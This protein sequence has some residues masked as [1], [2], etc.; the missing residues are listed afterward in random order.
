MIQAITYIE[1]KMVITGTSIEMLTVH[2]QYMNGQSVAIHH[3]IEHA[4]AK[5][6]AIKDGRQEDD[7]STI[8]L[9]AFACG[10][11]DGTPA[12][13]STSAR[14]SAPASLAKEELEDGVRAPAAATLVVPHRPHGVQRRTRTTA[15]D[16][17]QATASMYLLGSPIFLVES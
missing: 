17:P 6:E 14:P 16:G 13:A 7:A 11:S 4:N 1:N 15:A 8:E 3:S 9:D 2:A 5:I 10:G 12:P